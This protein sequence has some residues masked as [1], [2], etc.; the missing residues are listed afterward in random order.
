[1]IDGKNSM[2]MTGNLLKN[3]IKEEKKVIALTLEPR[4]N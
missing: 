4:E 3:L 2:M 1:M